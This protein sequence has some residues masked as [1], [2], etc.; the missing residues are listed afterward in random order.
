MKSFSPLPGSLFQAEDATNVLWVSYSP[1]ERK[2]EIAVP[3][4]LQSDFRFF[5]TTEKVGKAKRMWI[6]I[7]ACDV[8]THFNV[9]SL[10][11]HFVTAVEHCKK[12]KNVRSI[13]EMKQSHYI[14]CC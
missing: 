11:R 2:C 7:Q 3:V 12:S 8:T 6:D 14:Y 9:V 1:N 5:M 10:H 13:V 4:R